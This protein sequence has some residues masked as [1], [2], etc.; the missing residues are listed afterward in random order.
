MAGEVIP[1]DSA[2]LHFGMAQ[3]QAEVK[4]GAWQI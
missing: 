1:K 3:S 2:H 4:I